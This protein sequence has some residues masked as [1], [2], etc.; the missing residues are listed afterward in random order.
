[1]GPYVIATG[2]MATGHAIN[3]ISLTD[4][5]RVTLVK[6]NPIEI[7]LTFSNIAPLATY[8]PNRRIGHV[9][10]SVGVYLIQ[11]R[12]SNLRWL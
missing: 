2:V 7:I 12:S 6:E 5:D 4:D 10:F 9:N 11:G 3:F 1:M 8:Q